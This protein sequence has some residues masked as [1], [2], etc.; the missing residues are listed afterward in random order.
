VL[1]TP[2]LS[3]VICYLA[4]FQ[5]EE[6]GFQLFCSIIKSQPVRKMCKVSPA[7]PTTVIWLRLPARRD[8][9]QS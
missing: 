7:V 6:L 8:K 4:I 5:L 3:S 2:P 9:N 1:L